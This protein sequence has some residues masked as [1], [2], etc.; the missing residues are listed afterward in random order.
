MHIISIRLLGDREN[1]NVSVP[2]LRSPQLSGIVLGRVKPPF[3]S[4]V[5]LARENGAPY[6][7]TLASY[8]YNSIYLQH[9]CPHEN[10]YDIKTSR[11]FLD[12]LLYAQIFPETT[13][14]RVLASNHQHGGNSRI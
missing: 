13:D 7:M 3:L 14:Y 12:R 11:F 1:V 2:K 9:R 5:L 6:H 10:P 4:P 8:K